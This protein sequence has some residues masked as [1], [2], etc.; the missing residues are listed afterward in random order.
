MTKRLSRALPL[1]L[2]VGLC[3]LSYW[4]KDTGTYENDNSDFGCLVTK[5]WRAIRLVVDSGIHAKGCK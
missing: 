4:Q 1:T 5:M 2:K 3:T